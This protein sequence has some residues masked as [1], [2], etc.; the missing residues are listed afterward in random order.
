MV[1]HWI[2]DLESA[3]PN[4]RSVALQKLK[5]LGPEARAA[6]PALIAALEKATDDHQPVVA[7]ADAL[8][9]I[10][11]D[12]RAAVPLL[13]PLV[14]PDGGHVGGRGGDVVG[15][16]T[17]AVSRAI[18]RIGGEPA[19]ERLAMRSLLRSSGWVA[20]DMFPLPLWE[21]DG[22]LLLPRADRIIPC[23]A[24][25]LTDPDEY[26]RSRAVE[27]L[28]GYGSSQASS[29]APVL[30]AALKDP[31]PGVRVQA[32]LALSAVAPRRKSEAVA[33]LL[34]LLSNPEVTASIC[35]ALREI[36]GSEAI[37]ALLPLF[38]NPQAIW[39]VSHALRQMRGEAVVRLLPLL[40]QH[41]AE[42][43]FL[44]ILA[45][46]NIGEPSLPA[47]GNLLTDPEMRLEA[48][49]AMVAIDARQ[50]AP[51][52]PVLVDALERFDPAT[53]S[54]VQLPAL[55]AALGRIGTPAA[56]AAPLI[57]KLLQDEYASVRVSAASALACIA[58][59]APEWTADAVNGLLPLVAD[60]DDVY[61]VFW[62]ALAA[63]GG[64][65]P[66]AREVVPQLEMMLLEEEKRD[67]VGLSCPGDPAATIFSALVKIDPTAAARV[68]KDR[69]AEGQWNSLLM[70][71]G[72]LGPAVRPL[73]PVLEGFLTDATPENA[74]Q[75]KALLAGIK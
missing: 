20:S 69:R 48:A 67:T 74:N 63:M 36:G 38:P 41:T 51:A 12:A 11:P 58:P 49:M 70:A 16:R 4:V 17:Y 31:G 66:P 2:A 28:A 29:L 30:V 59:D 65:G 24:E 1:T 34:P 54:P 37:A 56:E 10:G 5:E 14:N 13:V 6:V 73:A 42:A 26:V 43:H 18:L 22:A 62:E 39:A 57:R 72:E 15:N 44:Y 68:L 61:G 25:L 40:R 45:L 27:I 3:D 71:L 21:W 75:L 19:Q 55:L 52:L 60:L 64:I 33:A 53:P 23:L 9:A 50:A 47:L 46:E 35:D 7:I 8:G 32:A